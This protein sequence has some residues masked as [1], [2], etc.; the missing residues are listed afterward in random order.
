MGYVRPVARK[1]PDTL[2]IHVRTNNLTKGV[3]TMRKVRKCM[4]VIPELDSTGNI[5]IGNS[6]IIHR[7]KNLAMKLKKPILS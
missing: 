3:N 6:S 1:K 2:L 4:D 7:T 5:Q